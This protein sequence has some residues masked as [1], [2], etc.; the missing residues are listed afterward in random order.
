MSIISRK[1][2][3]ISIGAVG[4]LL[5]LR[6]VAKYVAST[7]IYVAPAAP[8]TYYPDRN[9]DSKDDIKGA[10]QSS[11]SQKSQYQ[12][13]KQNSSLPIPHLNSRKKML[14]LPK[15]NN[16]SLKS[17]AATLIFYSKDK[18]TRSIPLPIDNYDSSANN[19]PN[20]HM[21][22]KADIVWAD[23]LDLPRQKSSLVS[24][25]MESIDSRIPKI[26]QGLRVCE[27]IS[28]G[29]SANVS[30]KSN[31]N[32]HRRSNFTTGGDLACD[33]VSDLV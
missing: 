2:V 8:L 27:G 1:T 22:Q 5:W 23:F 21:L 7:S 13:I 16:G 29:L 12:R 19:K 11:T 28:G 3:I 33:N 30:M 25:P 17:A 4:F 15:L 6:L 18:S 9:R 24:N 14:R 32:K 20:S 26:I 31:A 10:L